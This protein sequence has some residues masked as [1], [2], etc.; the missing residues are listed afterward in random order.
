M[1]WEPANDRMRMILINTRGIVMERTTF[2]DAGHQRGLNSS[3]TAY[4]PWSSGQVT[5]WI[6]LLFALVRRE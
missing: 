3:A 1:S 5:A 4:I 6:V 2:S